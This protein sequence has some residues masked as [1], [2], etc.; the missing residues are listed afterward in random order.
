MLDEVLE[1]E[2]NVRA[3]TNEAAAG[4]RAGV[5]KLEEFIEHLRVTLQHRGVQCSLRA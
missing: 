1:Y 3:N 4:L 2:V 5:I